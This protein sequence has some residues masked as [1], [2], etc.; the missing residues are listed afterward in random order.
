M[1][2]NISETFENQIKNS[3]KLASAGKSYFEIFSKM[4]DSLFMLI[5]SRLHKLPIELEELVPTWVEE[6]I[7]KSSTSDQNFSSSIFES[8]LFEKTAITYMQRNEKK[9]NRIADYGAGWGRIS[10]FL[11]RNTKSENLYLFEPNKNFHELSITCKIPGAKVLTDWNSQRPL[12]NYGNFD[13]IC[14]FSILTHASEWLI[15][16]IFDR[17]IELTKPGAMIFATIRPEEFILGNGGDADY[18]EDKSI[19]LQK[20]KN[21][22]VIY[23]PYNYS[24]Q[25]WGVTV[26]PLDYFQKYKSAF[27]IRD[28]LP[29]F[30]TP[31]QII[32][33]LERV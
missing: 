27:V 24:S 21:G 5:I 9:V 11:A 28:I 29:I 15:N 25:H 14:C 20:Y 31:N 32:V 18:L 2:Q 10:R 30:S 8:Y 26:I 7:R 12:D 16:N 19:A 17:W 13:L 22:E 23:A 4:D 1:Y 3:I 6:E 33:A